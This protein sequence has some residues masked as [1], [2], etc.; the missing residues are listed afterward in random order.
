MLR[1]LVLVG[2]AFALKTYVKR[3]WVVAVTANVVLFWSTGVPIRGVTSWYLWLLSLIGKTDFYPNLLDWHISRNSTIFLLEY[4]YVAL[5]VVLV[6]PVLLSRQFLKRRLLL[7]ALFG[8][9]LALTFENL[10]A[11]YI[12]ASIYGNWRLTRRVTLRQPVFIAAGWSMPV[13]LLIIYAKLSNPG[14]GTPLVSITKLGYSI[15]SEYRPLIFRLLIGFLILPYLLGLITDIIL[16]RSGVRIS[17]NHQLRTYIN[18]VVLGLCFS[19]FVGYFHSALATEFGRQSIG[20]QVLL[21]LSGF[22]ARQARHVRKVELRSANGE[23]NASV[24]GR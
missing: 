20:A 9:A 8:A 6:F 15:N 21:F 3:W 14:A 16:V 7:S 24:V 23:I 2:L 10:A 11:V 4:D 19:F 17:W 1:G 12:V 5:L 22:L 13:I 18:G